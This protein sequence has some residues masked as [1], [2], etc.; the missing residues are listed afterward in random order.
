MNRRGTAFFFFV[1]FWVL[2]VEGIA[3]KS[4][5]IQWRYFP[6]YNRIVRSLLIEMK[7]RNIV[8]YP[9]A[10]KLAMTTLLTN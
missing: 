8:E 1:R 9:D 5:D 7:K 2:Y 10:M 4:R 6:G 3:V